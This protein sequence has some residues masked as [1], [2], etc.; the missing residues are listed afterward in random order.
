MFDIIHKNDKGGITA[1]EFIKF[2]E[3][4]NEL[5]QGAATVSSYEGQEVAERIFQLRV[6]NEKDGVI[7]KQGFISRY[8]F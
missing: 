3:A 1:E 5:V 8:K 2:I 7:S 6:I 4:I